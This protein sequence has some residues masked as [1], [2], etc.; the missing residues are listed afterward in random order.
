M[1]NLPYLRRIFSAYI[2]RNNSQLSFWHETPAVSPCADREFLG[3]YFM[4]FTEK[5]MYSGPFDNR[6]IPLLDYKGR[7]GKQYNPIAIAQ[8]GL[9][10]F[11]L[12][13]QR[14]D[15]S[16]L[17]KSVSVAD[18]LVDNL[19]QN[20]SGIW[21]WNHL[22][23]WEYFKPL[24][25]PWYSALA[26]GQGISALLRIYNETG[27]T[28]YRDVADKAFQ[29]LLTPVNEGG[30]LYVDSEDLWWLEEYIVDP[31]THIINGFM[32]ALWGV[33]DYMKL[34]DDKSAEELWRQSLRTLRKN[35]LKFDNG[36]WSLYDLPKTGL[37]NVASFFYHSLHIVQLRIMAMLSGDMFFNKVADRW[38]S[39]KERSFNR[40]R[41]MLHKAFF[42]IF[43]Y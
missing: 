15:L 13:K 22:F 27:E 6:G 7:I 24:R 16:S 12:F 11:N 33:Y 3:N 14:N 21:V 8:Y 29:S 40:K 31:P 23:N 34:T 37:S 5:A 30:V 26:Q 32:W 42:K 28:R 20:E 39:F 19:T 41:A 9:G 35:I 2:L 17:K 43:Y 38:E 18:W 4:T 25:A 1:L 36:Y 10:N